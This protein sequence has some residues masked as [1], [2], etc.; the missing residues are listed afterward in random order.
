M[1]A[2]PLVAADHVL[3]PA[4]SVWKYRDEGATAGTAWRAA[5]FN[6][7]AWA[8]GPAPLGYGDG[9]EA[10]VL[11]F[12][13][14]ANNKFITTYFRNTFQVSNPAQFT[15]L[16]L[17]L[18]RDDGA[19]VYLNGVEV[20]R[21][22][23]PAGAIAN[24]TLATAAITGADETT[25][26]TT[27]IAPAALLAGT[28]VIAVEMH[29]SSVGSS[30]LRFDLSL[31]GA[32]SV[33]LTR[34]PYLQLGTPGSM[35]VRW[36]TNIATDSSVRFGST[37]GA[38]SGAVEHTNLTT[39]HEVKVTGL[40]ADAKYYYSV[41][42]TKATLAGDD[43][44][45][46]FHTNP[47]PGTVRPYRVWVLGDAGTGAAQQ[48]S[49]RNSYDAFNGA[50]R[51]DLWLMLGDN[52]Y[53]SG[54]DA[55]YQSHVFNIYPAMLKN[56]TLWP[57]LGNHDTAQSATPAATLPYFEMFTLPT[58]GEAGGVASAT[59]KYY[60]FDYGNMHFVA[61]DSMASSR[62]AAGVM[63][64][65]LQA[66]LAANT[67]RWTVAYW[68]HAPYT[69]GTHDSDTEIELLE[70]RQFLNPILE[71]GGVDLV[72]AGH[73]HS[74]ERSFLLD[75]HYG[76]SST[77]VASMK[78]DAGPGPYRKPGVN[79]HEGTV[80]VVAGTSGQAGSL[81]GTH[82]AMYTSLT[83]AGSLVM[84]VNGDSMD[85][86][87]LN[88]AGSISDSFSISKGVAVAEAP[89]A[90]ADL[91]AAA[92]P[93][94]QIDLAWI[95]NSDNEDGFRIERGTDGV[96]FTLIATVAANLTSYSDVGLAASTVYYYRVQAFNITG[97][98]AS[99]IATAS[100]PAS[101]TITL[102]PAG[103]NWRYLD[104]GTNQGTAWRANTFID[105]T[106]K[107]GQ[108][109]LG[110]G[111]GD[112]ATVVSYGRSASKK[113][114]TTYFRQAFTVSDPAQFSKVDVSLLRDDGAVVYLNGVEVFRSNMPSGTI[115]YKTLAS[116]AVVNA[117]ESTWYGCAISPGVLVAGTNVIT[118]EVHQNAA[119]S[120]D[121]SFD[122]KLTAQ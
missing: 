11:G 7:S 38:L 1:L 92:V 18:L 50:R 33:S 2:G 70:M 10:T 26:V 24:T 93:V 13:A 37:Q 55:E 116:T 36:R 58:Q 108:A 47:L 102:L 105:S 71:N 96:N 42:S 5:S 9:G 112:E 46:F 121:L 35:V 62:A 29:Q 30:D 64:Q 95:D 41:G 90:P 106:W 86:R 49:V 69:K 94:V 25:W 75:G 113:Y 31:A 119:N 39:E 28:N 77:L 43:A 57:A 103:S 72:L 22:N 19:V 32:E 100:T 118:V 52:A 107:V 67:R 61:L 51:T 89:V 8:A 87:F 97:S 34:G 45:T 16:T 101:P 20:W 3:L 68:H 40:L 76:V 59:E 73:S 82:P 21:V 114:I 65:W 14:D 109:Q 111:D 85:V 99:N 115:G 63:A 56:V 15:G 88:E 6:D 54:T 120:P 17:N 83:E 98:A 60:S 122:L 4:G 117:A 48:V 12:G 84:N 104:N 53:N 66:D 91:A 74:Y 79:G 81:L 78:K 27:S 110:Y 44:A 80:Y 23:L